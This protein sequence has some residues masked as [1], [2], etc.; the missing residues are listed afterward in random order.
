M[1]RAEQHTLEIVGSLHSPEALESAVSE[2]ASSGWDRSE[3]SILAQQ[4]LL[5]SDSVQG[6]ARELSDDPRAERQAVVADTDVRQG[7]TLAAGM[8]G[9]VGAFLA[10]GATILTGG[11]ALAA[12]VGAAVVGG[13]AAAAVERLAGA[14]GQH[15]DDHLSE[16]LAHGGMLLWARLHAPEEEARARAILSRHGATGIHVHPVGSEVLDR[17]ER[18]TAGRR[19]V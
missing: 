6:E 19:S 1:S 4:S 18:T 15:R 11:T 10:S 9:V 3:L 16:Q 5:D 8:A 12:V 2:F 14:V 13:G 7:R 17:P